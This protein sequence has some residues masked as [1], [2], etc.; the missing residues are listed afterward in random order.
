MAVISKGRLNQLRQKKIEIRKQQVAKTKAQKEKRQEL[1]NKRRQIIL[2]N[3]D[4]LKLRPRTQKT[5]NTIST[6]STKLNKQQRLISNMFHNISNHND[7][8]YGYGAYN[9]STGCKSCGG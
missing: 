5:K 6:K 3:Q 9:Y 8:G 7:L 2:E 4:K 1:L